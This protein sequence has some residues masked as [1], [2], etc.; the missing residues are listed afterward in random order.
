MITVL[1]AAGLRVAIFSNDHEPAHVH[2]FGDGDG[3]IN[4]TGD[5]G[6]HFV[7]INRMNRGEARRALELV[8]AN[9][10]ELLARWRKIHG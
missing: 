2:V 8:V 1:K 6:P 3:K 9:R 10:E 4:L 5:R 7:W